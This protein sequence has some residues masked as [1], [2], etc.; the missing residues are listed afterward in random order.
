[1]NTRM[2]DEL[3]FA[4]EDHLAGK[5]P[6]ADAERVARTLLPDMVPFDPTRPVSFPENGRLPTDDTQD[7]F[8]GILTNGKV[9]T[10]HIGPHSDLLADF[11][12]LGPPHAPV[13][14]QAAA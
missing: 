12:Y 6:R 3:Y 14:A 2:L 10:D 5:P 4:A 8:L 13:P 1:M 11:P 9:T 7:Y